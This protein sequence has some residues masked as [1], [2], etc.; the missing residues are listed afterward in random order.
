[1]S[2]KFDAITYLLKLLEPGR[3][4]E[5]QV[6][7]LSKLDSEQWESLIDEARKQGVAPILYPF[8]VSLEKTSDFKLP[9]REIL[10]QS[11]LTN[12]VRNTLILSEAEWLLTN[13]Q[14]AGIAAA[15]LKGIYL[16]ENVYGDIGARTM[17]DIDLLVKKSDLAACLQVLLGSGCQHTSYFSLEDE[18]IDTKHVPPMKTPGGVL[19]EIHWTLLEE[20]EPF[21]IDAA[22]LRERVMPVKIA[23]VD[24]L[25]LGVEDLILHLCM[26]LSY[27]HYLQLG[28]RGLLDV[29]MVIHKFREEIDWQVLVNIAKSW[30]IE[31]VTALTLELVETQLNIPVPS[32]VIDLLLPGGIDHELLEEARTLLLDK[33]V[34]EEHL[35]PDLVEMNASRNIFS[36]MKIGLQRVFIPRMALARIYN[37]PPNSMRIIGLYWERLK[38]LIRSYGGTMIKLSRNKEVV[39]PSVERAQSSYSLHDWMSSRN[40]LSS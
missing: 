28:L 37:I 22:A 39:L 24:A 29:A 11:Y 9:S 12:A 40:K 27:Q 16:L 15:G 10:Y 34:S 4:R 23:N 35:T 38:Y 33:M 25:V 32:E 36:K 21:S 6:E 18:N 3:T 20:D 31:R 8:V 5:E 26:H 2:E 14:N 19:L 13:L 7:L 30:G 17:N 1:M